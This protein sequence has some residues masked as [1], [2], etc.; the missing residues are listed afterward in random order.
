MP[1]PAQ[2]AL[3]IEELCTGKQPGDLIFTSPLGKTLQLNNWRKNV[4]DP[5]CKTAA[6]VGPTRPLTTLSISTQQ[7]QENRS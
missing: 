1:V 2:I 7:G 6:L 3:A 4:F 5:A